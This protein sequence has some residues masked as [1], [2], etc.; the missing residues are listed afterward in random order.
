MNIS[1]SI[2]Y[3][4]KIEFSIGGFFGGYET[5]SYTIDEDK[6][7][8]DVEHSLILKPSNLGDTEL[9][10]IDREYFLECFRDLHIG[11]WR[12]NYTPRRFGF[13]VLDGTQ[14]HLYVYFSNGHKPL[15]IEGSNDYPYNFDKLTE[16][17][18]IE[19]MCDDEE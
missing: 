8:V 4:N 12:K 9:E 7:R 16:L 11:E 18:N 5:K 13:E 19:T 10:E 2:P 14:W 15:K 1:T 17:F 6:V 3:I